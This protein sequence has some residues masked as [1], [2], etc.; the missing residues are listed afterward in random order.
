[1]KKI[2]GRI[3]RGV[4]IVLE[5]SNGNLEKSFENVVTEHEWLY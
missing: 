1:M 4:D 3:Y 2:G 5:I